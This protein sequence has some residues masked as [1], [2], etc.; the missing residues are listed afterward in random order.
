VPLIVISPFAKPGYVS[1]T[2][3]DHTS[4]LAFIEKRFLNGQPLTRRDA[5]A[6]TLEDLFDFGNAPSLNANVSPSLAAPPSP[7]DPGCSVQ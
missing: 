5:R 6:D 7:Q 1:H 4:I 2:V 3:G